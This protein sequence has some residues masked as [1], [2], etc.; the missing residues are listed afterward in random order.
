VFLKKANYGSDQITQE[1]PVQP[2]GSD[3]QAQQ[4]GN[5]FYSNDQTYPWR[6]WQTNNSGDDE[7]K[8]I[9]SWWAAQL[10]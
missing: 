5:V 3:R 4:N 2:N 6:S 10:Q 7:P 9:Q 1:S 8:D